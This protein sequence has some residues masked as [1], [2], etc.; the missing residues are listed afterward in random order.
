MTADIGDR[1][2]HRSAL[3]TPA[4]PATRARASAEH[5][6][7]LL[8]LDAGE[9]YRFGFS[10]DAC[11][12]CHS[13]EVAC[14][15]QNG[16]PAGTTWRRVGEI[17]GGDHPDTRALPP[18]DVVQPLPRAGVPRGLPDQRLREAGQRRRRPPRRRLHR[19]PVLHVELPVLGA[20][21]PARPPHRH[22][23]RHVPAAPRRRARA[24]RASAPARPTRSPSRRS[25]SPRGA[26]TTPPATRRSCRAPSS[27]CRPPASSCPHDVPA[28][29][30]R[31]ERLEPA[32][33]APALAARVADAAQPARRR[34]QRS[35]AGVGRAT[36]VIAAALAGVGAGRRARSTSAG[37]SWRG[38]RS[39]TC[40]AR[41]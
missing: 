28:R 35:T 6:P 27:R 25:T 17:E 30:V 15:E 38:R 8:P 4:P 19:L 40:A 39:A 34:R 16:L 2:R 32:A 33:R 31:G 7:E 37:R 26:P 3:A 18:L 20:G 13:C 11:I 24:R 23:V 10:M 14:A 1:R 36:G 29:D 9:Q 22:Q 5:G 41:G 21:V 12:G